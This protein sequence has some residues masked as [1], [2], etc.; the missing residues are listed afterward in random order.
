MNMTGAQ[1][2]RPRRRRGPAA[3]STAMAAPPHAGANTDREGPP[4]LAGGP[5][6]CSARL[7]REALLLH[8]ADGLGLRRR[9]HLVERALPAGRVAEAVLH[10]GEGGAHDRAPLEAGVHELAAGLEHLP[11][12]LAAVER[13]RRVGGGLL[14]ARGVGRVQ[15]ALRDEPGDAR[16]VG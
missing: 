6:R 12:V 16:L 7:D 10:L 13:D 3:F 4:A 14:L 9:Q 2:A 15:A 1:P 11:D 5:L 8:R